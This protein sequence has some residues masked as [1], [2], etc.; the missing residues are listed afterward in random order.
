M[1][2]FDLPRPQDIRKDDNKTESNKKEDIK[3]EA[4]TTKEEE[5]RK[6]EDKGE[7]ASFEFAVSVSTV[8]EEV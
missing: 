8:C 3:K 4:K 2:T 1:L 6:K 5:T 7:G